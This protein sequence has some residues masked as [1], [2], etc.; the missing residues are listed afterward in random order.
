M[1]TYEEA[2]AIALKLSKRVDTCNE[3]SKAYY[4]FEDTEE[5]FDGEPGVVIMKGTGKAKTFVQF[6]TDDDPEKRPLKVFKI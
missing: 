3:Y 1:L 5:D 4:F 2:K 6:I